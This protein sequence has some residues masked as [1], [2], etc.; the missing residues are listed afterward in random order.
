MFIRSLSIIVVLLSLSP[1]YAD[2][3]PLEFRDGG[4]Q[5]RYMD[6]I[7]EIRCLVCQ[8][9]S[10]ADSHADLAQDLRQEIFDMITEGKTNEEIIDFLVQRY[11]DFVLYRPPFKG[12]TILLWFLPFVFL[13]IA[14]L[15]VV[16]FIRFKTV[17]VEVSEL[18]RDDREK[19]DQALGERTGEGGGS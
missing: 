1:V 11:G 17:N 6:L 10:L 13:I 2:D 8:N 4:T 14:V 5:H 12:T 19:L 3:I 15:T 16:Y 9:Q 18:S 7:E